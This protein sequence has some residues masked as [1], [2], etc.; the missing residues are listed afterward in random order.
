MFDGINLYRLYP[1]DVTQDRS[2]TKLYI[3]VHTSCIYPTHNKAK[4]MCY[5]YR[6]ETADPFIVLKI[7]REEGRKKGSF[8]QICEREDSRPQ[9]SRMLA[10][11]PLSFRHPLDS[12]QY[13]P[14]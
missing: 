14:C 8:Y 5:V 4:P 9:R 3:I 11:G 1:R 12:M 7:G 13:G 10:D 6:T 2:P